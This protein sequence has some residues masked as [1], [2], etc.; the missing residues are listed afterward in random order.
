[1]HQQFHRLVHDH[2][3]APALVLGHRLLAATAQHLE[4]HSRGCGRD[5]S[6]MPP[7]VT[8]HDIAQLH[9]LVD[10]ATCRGRPS[11]SWAA[12]PPMFIPPPIR[13]CPCPPS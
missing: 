4:V 7:T 6:S 11:I 3:V 10:A 1:M 9:A 12:R 13:A 8:S 5:A 2:R